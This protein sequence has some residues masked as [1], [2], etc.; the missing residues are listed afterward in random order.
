MSSID[1]LPPHSL[2]AEE[3][4]LGSLLIDPDAIFEVSAFLKPKSFYSEPNRWVY[5]AIIE[6]YDK[7]EPLDFITLAE[8]L[9]AKDQLETMGGEGFL[10]DLLNA[11]PT[12]VNAQAYGR[13]VENSATRR[14]MI[15]A[16]SKIAELAYDEDEDIEIALERAEQALFGISEERTTKDLTPIKHVAREFME[17]VERMREN[18]EETIGIPTGFTDLDRLLS[19]LNKSDLVITAARPGMGK[20][21]SADTRILNPHTGERPTIQELYEQKSATLLTVNHDYK[22]IA[23]TPTDFIDDGIKPLY[24]V[25]TA[26][27]REIKTTLSHPF[28]TIDGWQPLENL[29]IGQRIAIPR[30]LPYF[31]GFDPPKA[32]PIILGYLLGDGC[33]TRSRIS[34]SNNNPRLREEF[35]AAVATFN[36][37]E[38]YLFEDGERVPTVHIRHAMP[39][40]KTRT[41]F[42]E[43]VSSLMREKAIST[44]TLAEKLSVSDSSV[45][46]WKRG[47]Y[48]PNRQNFEQLCVELSVLPE[49]LAPDGL[50]SIN[51]MHNGLGDWLREQGLWWAVGS[52]EKDVPTV[53]FTYTRKKLAL[54]L[55]RLFACDGSAYIQNGTQPVISY[56]TV[57]KEMAHSLQHLLLRFGIIAKLR[58]RQIK[59]QNSHRPAYQLRITSAPS[60]RKFVDE[61][62]IFGKETAIEAIWQRLNETNCNENL[63]T[64]PIEIWERI[65]EAKGTLS[66]S[67][68]ARNMGL[69]NDNTNLHVGK[70]APSRQRLRAMAGAIGTTNQDV[71]ELL[72][73]A[74]SDLY[75]DTITSIEYVGD[76]QVYD[77]TVPETHNF[78]ADDM[79]VHNTSLLLGMA[80]TAARKHGKRVAIFNL[81]MSAEQ[82]LMRMI[83]SET[84]IDSQ[85][86]R[87]G[88]IYESELGLFYEAV[89]RL[90]E[91]Y[92]YID[93]TANMT[94]RQMRTKARRLYAERGLDLIIV[95]YLQLMASDR[96]N[97]NRVMEISDISRGLK[98]LARELNI[99]VVAAAQLS[100]SVESR[101]D[102]RPMLSDLRD[103]GSI[104]QDADVV[105]F[106]YRDEYYNPE[107]T[108]R[109]GIAEVIIAKHRN[110]PTGTVDL[111]WQD[112][113][114]SFKNLQ[115]QEID[116]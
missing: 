16:A 99:P 42:G 101:Q 70:R 64:I 111:F 68:I 44:R 53:V 73:L 49:T 61:I 107:T 6:L 71:S 40:P 17:R 1:R 92:I 22:L 25:V 30:E 74:E 69:G 86:L 57:S 38:S 104:E 12:S 105:T 19:G 63:D 26:L 79:L 55:N 52:A 11:V 82:L 35:A 3:A 50:A 47:L 84:Q 89:G 109:P 91:S 110:G 21:V 97:N 20:C 87:K 39:R 32:E 8:A 108:E 83:S 59:Y 18:P 94:P 90:A 7:R 65:S 88:K 13:L 102:K 51:G 5:E 76:E 113:L 60:M 114:A 37:A 29:T 93:D 54:F 10:I 116:L 2:E 23:T 85:R 34:F 15:R 62:G 95:D 98:L 28:L 78:I 115:R 27:G 36:G 66:W 72:A 112:N 43:R 56:S 48:G 24:R 77:L 106:I 41:L 31:G 81:E 9:R 80:L 14:N 46:N 45:Q 33:L 67:Q 100:R 96:N 58:S 4:V 103:S 75:W